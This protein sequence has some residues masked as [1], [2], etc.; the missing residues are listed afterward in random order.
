MSAY[1]E[2]VKTMAAASNRVLL[3]RAMRFRRCTSNFQMPSLNTKTTSELPAIQFMDG[4]EGNE[5]GDGQDDDYGNFDENVDDDER[6]QEEE[7]EEN[8]DNDSVNMDDAPN[9]AED[10]RCQFGV[11]DIH[12]ETDLRNRSGAVNKSLSK[13][14]MDIVYPKVEIL[15]KFD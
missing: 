11:N 13:R 12:L 4:F 15:V 9:V 2:N 10:E 8:S 1:L 6:E 14:I 5:D 3:N 7:Q